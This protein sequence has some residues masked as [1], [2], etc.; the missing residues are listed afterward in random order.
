M[1]FNDE[2][3]EDILVGVGDDVER[4]AVSFKNSSL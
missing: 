4:V 1:T 2:T 3:G